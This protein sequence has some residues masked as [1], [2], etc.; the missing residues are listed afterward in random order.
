[1]TLCA[2]RDLL[3]VSSCLPN[4]I[5]EV[6]HLE[7]FHNPWQAQSC[8]RPPGGAGRGARRGARFWR[9][10]RPQT[11][12]VALPAKAAD[13]HSMGHNS[14]GPSPNLAN[15]RFGRACG[16]DTGTAGLRGTSCAQTAASE[17]RER[18]LSSEIESIEAKY[19]AERNALRATHRLVQ[20]APKCPA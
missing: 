4:R 10:R 12:A 17:A 19:I 8:S 9:R 6:E 11:R 18:A 1:M 14:V 13:P 20:A 16:A 7:S 3:K 2:Q 5:L 15:A